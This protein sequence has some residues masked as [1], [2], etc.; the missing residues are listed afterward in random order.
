MNWRIKV[1]DPRSGGLD[2]K[3]KKSDGNGGSLKDV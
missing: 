3:T 2:A 1:L